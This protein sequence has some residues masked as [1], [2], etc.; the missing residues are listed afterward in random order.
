MN[1]S[2][3]GRTFREARL[4][5]RQTQQEVATATGVSTP[6]ISQFERGLLPDLGSLRLLALFRQVGLE[7]GPRPAGQGR[8]LDDVADELNA[9]QREAAGGLPTVHRVRHKRAQAT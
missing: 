1:L 6:T 3:L 4:L 7:L 2:E 8:T 9:A 5:S